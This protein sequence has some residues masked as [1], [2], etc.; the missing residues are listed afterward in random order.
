MP[1]RR[2]IVV[3]ESSGFQMVI[4]GVDAH[5]Q[6]HS[7]VAVDGVGRPLGER[8]TQTTTAANHRALRWALKSFGPDLLWAVEDVRFLTVRLEKDLLDAGQKVIRVPPHLVAQGRRS[9]RTPG[10]PTPSTRWRSPE[11]PCT[12]EGPSRR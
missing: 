10:S 3:V 6:S 8:T 9:A 2:R 1:P 4:I 5:K 12:R 11:W 7:M